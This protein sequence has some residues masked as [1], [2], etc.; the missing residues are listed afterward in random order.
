M[1]QYYILRRHYLPRG[2]DS[3]DDIAAA[4]WLDNRYWENMSV[5]V[6]NGIGT[7]FKGN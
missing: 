4:L 5:A 2:D 6:A 3:L 7:A 1:E